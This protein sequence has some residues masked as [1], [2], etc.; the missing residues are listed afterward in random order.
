MH[1]GCVQAILSNQSAS[2][3]L[4]TQSCCEARRSWE[5]CLLLLQVCDQPHPLL[6]KDIV[7]HCLRARLS[8]AYAGMK[9]G[10]SGTPPCSRT[11]TICQH[12][13]VLPHP[14]QLYSNMQEPGQARQDVTLAGA[15]C[16]REPPAVAWSRRKKVSSVDLDH[17]YTSVEQQMILHSFTATSRLVVS[18]GPSFSLPIGVTVVGSH[19]C[20]RSATW[21][22]ARWTSS[23]RCSA[24]SRPSPTR[25]CRSF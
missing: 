9:V 14:W 19:A 20:R 23:P 21:G 1:D 22:T 6:V 7:R 16:M 5:K 10:P 13:W 18:F 2:R 12:S 8:D 25:T 17:F 24:W 15:A 11:S 4:S 3:L